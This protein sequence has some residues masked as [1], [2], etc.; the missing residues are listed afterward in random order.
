MTPA[1]LAAQRRRWAK[2]GKH[3]V[4]TNGVF[5][6]LHAGHVELLQKARAKGDVLIVGLNSDDSARRLN[7]GP[8]RPINKFSDRAAV[9][10]ALSCVDAVVG[11]SQDTPTA[12]IK[13]LRPDILV[14]GADY[15]SGQIAGAQF[16]GKVVRIALKK[17]YSTTGLIARLQ[18]LS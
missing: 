8:K 2:Q 6:I 11:F 12:L 13:R 16:A 17:G 5:D 10:T 1:K 3:V 7:K 15:K 18:G 14:K 9:L 4:F